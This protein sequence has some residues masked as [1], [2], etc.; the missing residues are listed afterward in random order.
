VKR[1]AFSILLL[2]IA[3]AALSAAEE[4]LTMFS[5][6][7]ETRYFSATG[8]ERFP[9]G[10]ERIAE[11]I[12]SAGITAL[13][14]GL[15]VSAV[16]WLLAWTL[17]ARV[18]KPRNSHAFTLIPFAGLLSGA[19]LSFVVWLLSGGWSP[20]ALFGFMAT[21]ALALSIAFYFRSHPL[22]PDETAPTH[23]VA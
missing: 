10:F 8:E 17:S 15:L 7:V 2:T 19:F 23:K 13:L 6:G 5:S 12:A 3:F 11:T 9:S 22:T 14:P 20:P 18:R 21:G 1:H 4:L 16:L